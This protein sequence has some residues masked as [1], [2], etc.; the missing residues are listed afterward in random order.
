MMNAKD[1]LRLVAHS[2]TRWGGQISMAQATQ[3]GLVV[4][5]D[6]GANLWEAGTG[7]SQME[8][9]IR[10]LLCAHFPELDLVTLPPE[11]CVT[12]MV[13]DSRVVTKHY[14]KITEQHESP[15]MTQL[16]RRTRDRY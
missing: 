15:A 13:G 8:T 7:S 3:E 14:Y 11:R 5:I 1:I 4:C 12:Q 10:T 2:A 9:E 6:S 16:R